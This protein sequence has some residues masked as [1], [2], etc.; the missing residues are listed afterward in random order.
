MYF[1]VN[2]SII[3]K[4]FY[5]SKTEDVMTDL[6]QEDYRPS[7]N[8]LV[9]L[10]DVFNK[11][12]FKNELP[13]IEVVNEFF[14]TNSEL[15]RFYY[16]KIIAQ[17]RAGKLTSI[18]SEDLKC[19]IAINSSIAFTKKQLCETFLHEM[20][21]LWQFVEH[22][23]SIFIDG[24]HETLFLDKARV[25]S[26]ISPFSVTATCDQELGDRFT[27]DFYSEITDNPVLCLLY[28]DGQKLG[29]ASIPMGFIDIIVPI[30]F[31]N[32]R[33]SNIEFYKPLN[34]T[35]LKKI[36]PIFGTKK[37]RAINLAIKCKLFPNTVETQEFT[38]ASWYDISRLFDF[39][40]DTKFIIGFSRKGVYRKP[41]EE[42]IRLN[43][44]RNNILTEN[45]STPNI[46][47]VEEYVNQSGDKKI[48]IE[49][50]EEERDDKFIVYG[51]IV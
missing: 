2:M 26:T 47:D 8:E 23:A 36:D 35:L 10:F 16:S 31:N 32:K 39:K 5:E 27:N 11:N 14:N 22:P 21:H 25:I 37:E 12:Y 7:K 38:C 13:K 18:R 19:Y 41:L 43:Y 50:I 48:H 28:K 45:V 17:N 3:S 46:D 24:G 33:Y 20:I 30:I 6:N 34:E 44:N 49:E 29:V 40:K 42:T 1:E 4:R 15:G 51:F 9:E